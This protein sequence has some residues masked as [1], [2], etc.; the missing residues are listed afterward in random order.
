MAC[1]TRSPRPSLAPIAVAGLVCAVGAGACG[2][3][4]AAL[5]HLVEARQHA[6]DLRVD[7][8]TAND[9]SN[10]AV[11]ADTD[12][13]SIASAHEAEQAM[14]AVQRDID[15]LRP[16]L[17]GLGYTDE[18]GLLGQ[19]AARFKD[20]EDVERRILDLAVENSNLKAERLSFGAGADA[21]EAFKGALD[22]IDAATP[23]DE[24]WHVRALTADAVANLRAIQV[25]EAPHIAASDDAVMAQ[26]ET[27]MKA[28]ETAVRSD[29]A[30]LAALR[31]SS[32]QAI[33]DAT[34]ALN[35]FMDVHAQILVLSHQNTNVRSLAMALKDKPAVVAD[36]DA[37]LRDLTDALAKRGYR[38]GWWR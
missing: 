19:F 22:R 21:A 1:G 16:L 2:N 38:T 17:Q 32:R 35:G 28:A 33:G 10:R 37:R 3:V 9:A 15:A 7:F 26:L 4:N 34:T 30:A 20:Y 29:L 14:T 5:E 36:C 13:A 6:A 18:T 24:R 23:P 31:P 25:L 27:R 8:T 11:M 12:E